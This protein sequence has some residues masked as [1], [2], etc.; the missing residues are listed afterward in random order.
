MCPKL[1]YILLY[2]ILILYHIH[3]ET[4]IAE[5]DVFLYRNTN[6]NVNWPE[7]RNVFSSEN[8]S[9]R[10]IFKGKEIFSMYAN[11]KQERPDLDG[12]FYVSAFFLRIL[13]LF[14]TLSASR[15][16]YI[17]GDNQLCYQNRF[18]MTDY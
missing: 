7:L 18:C 6:K 13:P 11:R 10:I 4:D 1:G 15:I 16:N 2:K 9:L 5:K 3:F 14:S 17:P 12:G 8:I